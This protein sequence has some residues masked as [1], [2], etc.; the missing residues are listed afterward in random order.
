MAGS[1]S[2][3]ADHFETRIFIL[4]ARTG[5]HHL[6]E[7]RGQFLHGFGARHG[8]FDGELCSSRI[9]FSGSKTAISSST[10]KSL[11]FIKAPRTKLSNPQVY[12]CT[13]KGRSFPWDSLH[14]PRPLRRNVTFDDISLQQL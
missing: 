5:E 9:A 11:G 3:R 12:G 1:T 2:L 8:S 14:H 4:H 6:R 13:R 10:R 7:A